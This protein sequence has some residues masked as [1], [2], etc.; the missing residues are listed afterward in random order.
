MQSILV[1]AWTTREPAVADHKDPRLDG[2]SKIV[3]PL[4]AAPR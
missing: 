2:Q 3:N 4:P 1:D